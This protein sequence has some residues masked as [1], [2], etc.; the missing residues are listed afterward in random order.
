MKIRFLT[1]VDDQLFTHNEYV[2]SIDVHKT[3]IKTCFELQQSLIDHEVADAMDYDY[4]NDYFEAVSQLN[5]TETKIDKL[6]ALVH[7]DNLQ[8][9]AILEDVQ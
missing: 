3:N 4:M 8:L 5:L 6:L 1:R 7:K 2:F 9:Y